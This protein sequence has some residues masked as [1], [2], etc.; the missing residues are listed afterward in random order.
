[1]DDDTKAIRKAIAAAAASGAVL[2]FPSGTYIV[3]PQRGDEPDRMLF[4]LPSGLTLCG[5]GAESIIKIADHVG[6]YLTIFGSSEQYPSNITFRNLFINQNAQNA[7]K[8]DAE[9]GAGEYFTRLYAIRLMDCVNFTVDSCHFTYCGA[10]SINVGGPNARSVQIMNSTFRFEPLVVIGQDDHLRHGYDNSGIYIHSTDHVIARNTF[11]APWPPPAAVTQGPP[12]SFD[13][14]KAGGAIETH[15]GPSLVTGNLIDGF[16]VGI[17]VVGGDAG[18]P[19]ANPPVVADPAGEPN[20][21]KVMGNT[22]RHVNSGIVLWSPAGYPLQDVQIIGNTIEISNKAWSD[23]APGG[24]SSLGIKLVDS[25]PVYG[26]A[27]ADM[28]ISE[29]IISFELSPHPATQGADYY[30]YGIGLCASGPITNVTVTNNVILNSPCKGIDISD[31]HVLGITAS[32]AK[33]VKIF[34]NLIDNAGCDISA[35]DQNRAAISSSARQLLN[36][37]INDNQISFPSNP[38]AVV[39]LPLHRYAFYVST[40]AT[41]SGVFIY[42]N[43]I[44]A[45]V[46]VESVILGGGITEAPPL[47]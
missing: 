13:W 24:N 37:F 40:G 18:F 39:P 12:P 22:M 8:V 46:A 43:H 10:N 15:R 45:S 6:Y 23:A 1:V 17:N 26:Y 29:N 42:N 31:L 5:D 16:S 19:A 44:T 21:I 9:G 25:P 35:A 47:I 14:N 27:Y 11:T 32:P 2:Y 41:T 36:C 20:G 30:T 7:S 34:R 4:D 33:G 3:S 38:I 28:N